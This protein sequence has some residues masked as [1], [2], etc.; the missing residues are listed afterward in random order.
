VGAPSILVV[1]AGFAGAA[2]AR[3]LAEAGLSV[4]VIDRR[5]H[6]AGNA[7]DI[8]DTNGVRVHR[9]GPHLFHT[10]MAP[11]VAWLRRFG[12]WVPYR[13]RVRARLENG[14]LVPL[15][16][17]LDTINMVFG[18]NL[19]GEAEAA[20][21]L[22]RISTPIAEPRDA[23]EYLRSRIGQTLTDLLFRPYTKKMWG[24][25]LEE[26]DPAVV[27]R[28]P[29]RLDRGDGYF[30]KDRYQLLP[31][32]G[33]TAVV[34]R[35]LQHSHITVQTGTIFVPGMERD[36]DFCFNSMAIDEFF[37]Y[38]LG[39]LP[40]RS[41]RFHHKTVTEWDA[42]PWSVRNYTDDSPFTRETWWHCL[43]GHVIEETG[44]R[45]ITVEEPCDYRDNAR[46]RYYPVRT[47]DHRYQAL[48]R[49]YARL[50]EQKP[51]MRFIGRCGT[52]QYLDMDQVIN[53]SL[54][55]ARRWLKERL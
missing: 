2:Y 12:E 38:R 28:L 31:R 11:V 40:Y 51:R 1:G 4:H 39:E 35:I 21:F 48:Y 49:D 34:E 33:Y 29:V 23:G 22:H 36:F 7:A 47:A 14:T 19:P 41:I 5:D 17:N 25:D 52:Y 37:D 44:H 30:P 16:I 53:Q 50:A 27:A 46:E 3:T 43:P 10:N 42:S 18:E 6:V 20:A 54:A 15:P 9:Y 8:V 55:G 24:L 45:T 26:M 32:D 13:H